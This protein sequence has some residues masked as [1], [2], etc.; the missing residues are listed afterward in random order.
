MMEKRTA[1]ESSVNRIHCLRKS[2][3]LLYNYEFAEEL[4][5]LCILCF[6]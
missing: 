4:M 6:V 5:V 1:G 2:F 3:V